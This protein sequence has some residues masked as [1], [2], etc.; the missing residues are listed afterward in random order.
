MKS[1]TSPFDTGSDTETYEV[2]PTPDR[3]S[4]ANPRP[5]HTRLL[6]ENGIYLLESIYLEDIARDKVYEFLFVML[7][8][9]IKGATGSMG[10][11]AG[12]GLNGDVCEGC[13]AC[14]SDRLRYRIP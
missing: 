8:L 3:R 14:E 13:G 12:D 1:D 9:K 5:V 7:P 2:M 11:S 10:G 4:P 6:V